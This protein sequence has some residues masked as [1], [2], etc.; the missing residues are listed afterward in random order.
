MGGQDKEPRLAQVGVGNFA[1]HHELLD[2]GGSVLLAYATRHTEAG[3]AFHVVASLKL[4]FM[5]KHW[6]EEELARLRKNRRWPLWT[7]TT[8]WWPVQPWV[9]QKPVPAVDF[10]T[11]VPL[12]KRCTAGVFR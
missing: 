11:K 7:K 5:G 1:Y 9:A 8:R 4:D 10:S 6:S 3:Q 12:A 2:G